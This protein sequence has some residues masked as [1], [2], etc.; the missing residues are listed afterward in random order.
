MGSGPLH[1]SG[2]CRHHA[3]LLQTAGAARARTVGAE[4]RS[5]TRRLECRH[6]TTSVHNP[7]FDVAAV[8]NPR[9]VLTVHELCF[10]KGGKMDSAGTKDS[11]PRSSVGGV[12]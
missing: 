11:K 10:P 5:A 2:S 3:R 7:G 1:A 6:A 8:P 9:N 4:V 12:I